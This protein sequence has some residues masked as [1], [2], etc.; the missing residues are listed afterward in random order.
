[1]MKKIIASCY[2]FAGLIIFI[3]LTML[4]AAENT[5]QNNEMVEIAVDWQKLYA[6]D[7]WS[8]FYTETRIDENTIVYLKI[9][10][11]NFIR[12]NLEH[13]VREE[14]IE[15]Y[16]VM[17][18]L[19]SQVFGL[20]EEVPLLPERTKENKFLASLD[21]WRQE[22]IN[23]EKSLSK[24]LNRFTSTVYLEDTETELLQEKIEDKSTDPQ[25]IGKAVVNHLED[26]RA[27]A[28]EN[29][30]SSETATEAYFASA[31][32]ERQL[33]IHD[34]VINKFKAFFTAGRSAYKGKRI[35]LGQKESGTKVTA[36]LS[37]VRSK[38]P[39]SLP[40]ATAG[41]KNLQ[42]LLIQYF[43]QSSMPV[44]FHMG[45][46]LSS[47][48]EAGFEKVRLAAGNDVFA[49][50]K[51]EKLSQNLSAFLSYELWISNN[52]ERS[53]ALTLGT[54]L[55]EPGEKIYLGASIKLFRRVFITLAG[56]SAEI[57]RGVVKENSDP[58]IKLFQ[59]IQKVKKW[60]MVVAV[61]IS[62]F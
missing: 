61:S 22:L 47:L 58:Q 7:T 41:Q 56:V 16:K 20:A 30:F 35:R 23:R 50:I 43:V 10:N 38:E 39:E 36:V 1:M 18:D 37:P 9:S 29:I 45:Y 5:S 2:F 27:N 12:F 55:A 33:Q 8:V 3:H 53:L 51:D 15:S 26:L 31:L 59:T 48:G 57:T 17:E 11:F 52:L 21:T 28:Y 46:A 25:A 62:P 19:W 32:Y 13:E 6:A 44:V 24:F 40:K 14:M 34:E 49:Q 60:G 54:G 42:P 4:Q